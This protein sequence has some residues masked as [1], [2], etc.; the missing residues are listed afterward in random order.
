MN[1][2][3]QNLRFA[4]GERTVLRE[5]GFAAQAGEVWAVLG[6]NGAG[7]STL[8]RCILGLLR[9]DAGKV[10]LDGL[11]T[12]ALPRR[13]LA[14]KIA[15]IPQRH[16]F[17]FSYAVRDVV[18]MGTA[19][20]VRPLAVPGAAEQAR[21]EDALRLLGLEGLAN[22]WF[23]QLSGGEQQ[24]VL[25]ARALAQQA[26]LLLLDEPTS[27]LDFGNQARVL[28]ALR[29]LAG[30]GYTVLFSSHNPQH[31]LSWADRVLA[32]HEGRVAAAGAA[33]EVITEELLTRLYGLRCRLIND[34]GDAVVITESNKGAISL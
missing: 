20:Q 14:Q 25:I 21:V 34:H 27:N 10:L 12:A 24:L 5:I 6:E 33:N 15:Y 1:L 9:P 3:V 31:A 17:A 2:S 23:P 18:L 7:K 8:F 22:R 28:S 11:D 19:G 30:Q 16:E 13:Q 29:D 4:Y 32:L 26:R